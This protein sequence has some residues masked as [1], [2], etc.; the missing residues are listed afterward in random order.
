MIQIN[1]KNFQKMEIRS[2]QSRGQIRKRIYKA[3][4]RPRKDHQKV[5]LLKAKDKDSNKS[6]F[7]TDQNQAKKLFHEVLVQCKVS[8]SLYRELSSKTISKS[9]EKQ[10]ENYSQLRKVV[11][12]QE[13]NYHEKDR[14]L[15]L[16]IFRDF[17]YK[18]KIVP[19]YK[20]WRG[21]SQH[22]KKQKRSLLSLVL[23]KEAKNKIYVMNEFRKCVQYY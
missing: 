9:I 17:V 21:Q 13:N 3:I 2:H 7:Q 4:A 12:K 15:L 10:R 1:R 18:C 5:E 6:S 19:V 16:R 20:Q 14:F 23:R 11:L 8:R 22:F